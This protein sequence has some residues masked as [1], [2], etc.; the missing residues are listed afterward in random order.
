MAI[1]IF[2]VA[3]AAFLDSVVAGVEVVD[4]LVICNNLHRTQKQLYF[5]PPHYVLDLPCCYTLK[6]KGSRNNT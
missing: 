6:D 2:L 5:Q 1:L 4:V 3:A